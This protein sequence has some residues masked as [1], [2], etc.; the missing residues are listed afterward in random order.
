MTLPASGAISLRDVNVELGLPIGNPISLNDTAVR[1]L[2]GKPSGSISLADGYGKS[3]SQL[4]FNTT[5]GIYV[6]N[7]GD[8][9][10]GYSSVNIYADGTIVYQAYT[11]GAAAPTPSA[12][13]AWY[14]PV[15]GGIGATHSVQFIGTLDAKGVSC[16]VFGTEYNA[17]AISTPWVNLA[18]NRGLY[19]S[20]D[21]YGGAAISILSGIL[22]IRNNSTLVTISRPYNHANSN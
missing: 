13:T 18:V 21:I 22:Y 8:G 17:G 20:N 1:T 14:S 15:T 12:P 3:N 7:Y 10:G 11:S 6:T 5:G 16:S 9:E 4:A 2:F 19:M